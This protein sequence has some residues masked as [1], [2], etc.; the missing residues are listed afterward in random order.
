MVPP[1]P[2]FEKIRTINNESILRGLILFWQVKKTRILTSTT[3]E[4]KQ[5]TNKCYLF[6]FFFLADLMTDIVCLLDLPHCNNCCTVWVAGER[7]D[8][9]SFWLQEFDISTCNVPV[10]QNTLFISCHHDV[11]A[12]SGPVDGCD[13]ALVSWRNLKQRWIIMQCSGTYSNLQFRALSGNSDTN[14]HFTKVLNIKPRP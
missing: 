9:P 8:M 6:F 1:P 12:W 14:K 11:L 13:F 2:H 10:D 3:S 4:Q 7:I 5:Q